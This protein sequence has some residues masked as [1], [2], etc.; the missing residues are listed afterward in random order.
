[1]DIFEFAMQMELDGKSFYEKR[2]AATKHR[3]LKSMLLMLAE[4]EQKHY[5]FFRRMK[6]GKTTLAEAEIDARSEALDK[7]R[8]IFVEMSNNS[9]GKQFSEDE[10][11]A[12]N[13]A[14]KIE[15]K[16]VKFYSEKAAVEPDAIRKRLLSIIAA[17][18]K[19]H[20]HMIDGVLSY[21]KYP[22]SFADSAQFKNFQSL[23]GH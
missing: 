16:A 18:E 6:E 21:L 3:E 14:M 22:E 15:E 1:M 2:A 4:E 17:E 23:E 12:W 7:A 8:N 5:N 10:L 9:E 20:V 19:N 11:S 13:E